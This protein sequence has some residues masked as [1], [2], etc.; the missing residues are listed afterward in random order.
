MKYSKIARFS[1]PLTLEC[2]ST[3]SVA[4]MTKMHRYKVVENS[5]FVTDLFTLCLFRGINVVV[6]ERQSVRVAKKGILPNWGVVSGELKEVG[7]RG[8]RHSIDLID[9][10]VEADY[11]INQ[12]VQLCARLTL[13]QKR[14]KF[15][16]T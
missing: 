16:H 8:L 6:T 7:S 3:F 15:K 13:T 10:C 11:Y 14:P 2:R 9:M 5:F 12:L 1:A 4:E